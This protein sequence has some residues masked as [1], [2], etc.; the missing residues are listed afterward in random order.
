MRVWRCGLNGEGAEVWT[1]GEGV[2][3]WTDGEGVEVWTDGKVWRCGLMVR[4]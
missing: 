4:V 3:V 1:D 2:E